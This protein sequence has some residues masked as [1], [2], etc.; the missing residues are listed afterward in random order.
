MIF[1]SLEE[2]SMEKIIGLRRANRVINWLLMPAAVF[3]LTYLFSVGMNAFVHL[4][5]I[6]GS[7]V[8]WI[9]T[10]IAW[11]TFFPILWALLWATKPVDDLVAQ[12]YANASLVEWLNQGEEN[13]H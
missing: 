2:V 1:F 11:M 10:G 4:M 3:G 9:Y 6:G 12:I 13:L 8:A 7:G 5:G